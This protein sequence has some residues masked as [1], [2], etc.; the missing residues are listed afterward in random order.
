VWTDFSNPAHITAPISPSLRPRGPL[1]GPILRSH[2]HLLAWPTCQ[3][4]GKQGSCALCFWFVGP[5][6]LSLCTRVTLRCGARPLGSS[7][8]SD[9]IPTSADAIDQNPNNIRGNRVIPLNP[10]PASDSVSIKYGA[11]VTS[12]EHWSCDRRAML[13]MDWTPRSMA[14]APCRCSEARAPPW[15]RLP[16]LGLRRYAIKLEANLSYPNRHDDKRDCLS[17]STCDDVRDQ[18]RENK[19]ALCGSP[20]NARRRDGWP[21]CRATWAIA[22]HRSGFFIKGSSSYWRRDRFVLGASTGETFS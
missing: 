7:L 20:S 3:S 11:L 6:S 4:C 13:S 14:G 1:A 9:T 5:V 18:G 16:G 2:R 8:S 22:L 12:A 21:R 17:T 19:N 15:T 10:P